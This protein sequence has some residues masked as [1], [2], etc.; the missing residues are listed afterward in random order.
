MVVVVGMFLAFSGLKPMQSSEHRQNPVQE[1]KDAYASVMSHLE[2]DGDFLMILNAENGVKQ[3]SASLAN[4]AKV[5]SGFANDAGEEK[6]GATF[7]SVSAKLPDFLED[8]GLLSLKAIGASVVPNGDGTFRG[9]RFVLRD[10]PAAQ[11]PL[12][13]AIANGEPRTLVSHGYLTEDIAFAA[14][15]T[16]DPSAVLEFVRSVVS[17]LVP[18]LKSP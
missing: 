9:R 2:P 17:E 14:S 13:R 11:K 8:N 5:L 12:W 1:S 6:V 4:V 15:T 3:A 16:A 10:A 7:A 18:S